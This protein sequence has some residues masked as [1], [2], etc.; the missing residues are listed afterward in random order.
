VFFENLK[1]QRFKYNDGT[2]NRYHTGFIAQ[3]VEEA[4]ELSELSQ[5]EFAGI[6]TFDANTD[7][8][9][10]ALRYEEFIS[11]N[12]YEIQ[13]LKKRVADQEAR[14]TELEEVIKN[15]KTE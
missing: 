11:P 13:K 5:N 4:L 1:P 2:S 15:L 10:K 9:T 7:K 3:E 14:I 12:T 6:V 8:E